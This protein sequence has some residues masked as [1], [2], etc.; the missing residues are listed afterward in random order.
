[1]RVALVSDAGIRCVDI[2]Q[3]YILWDDGGKEEAEARAGVSWEKGTDGRGSTEF[4]GVLRLAVLA[5]DD[6]A[7][8]NQQY[9]VQVYVDTAR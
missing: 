2:G 7:Y 8:I 6:T 4:I 3:N 1:V 5:Q 9:V